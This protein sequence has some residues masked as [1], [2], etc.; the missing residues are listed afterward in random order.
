MAFTEC[1][2]SH[3]SH[4]M[5]Q[6]DCD[7]ANEGLKP[8]AMSWQ[9]YMPPIQRFSKFLQ[10][11][12]ARMRTVPSNQITEGFEFC[13]RIGSHSWR[14]CNQKLQELGKI[15]IISV[16]ILIPRLFPPPVL[17]TLKNC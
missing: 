17:H 11:P 5:F 4:S 15:L 8:Q 16:P 10:H 9:N 6:T 7:Q 3:H 14:C 12:V 2:S 1:K 13:S